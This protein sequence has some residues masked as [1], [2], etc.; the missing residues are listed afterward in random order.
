[1][2]RLEAGAILGYF[3]DTNVYVYCFVFENIM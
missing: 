2:R 3:V 1:M